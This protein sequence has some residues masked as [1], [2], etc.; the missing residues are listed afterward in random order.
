MS[1]VM[2]RYHPGNKEQP[3]YIEIYVDNQLEGKSW[4]DLKLPILRNWMFANVLY[5]EIGHHIQYTSK[6]KLVKRE[7][8]AA[9]YA[10]CLRKNFSRQRYA[11]FRPL[12]NAFY[13]GIKKSVW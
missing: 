8:F 13:W 5:H 10:S 9:N 12:F 7:N 11:C 3:A 1:L 4:Y 6:L 2:G